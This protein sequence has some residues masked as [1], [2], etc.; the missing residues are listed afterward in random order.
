MRL[1][2]RFSRIGDEAAIAAYLRQSIVNLVR[3]HWRKRGIERAYLR[4]EGPKLVAETSTLP[5]LD[6]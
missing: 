6:D 5:D 1:I 2:A 4:S 3:K